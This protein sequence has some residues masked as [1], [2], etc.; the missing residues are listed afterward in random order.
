MKILFQ[1]AEALGFSLLFLKR[2]FWEAMRKITALRAGGGHRG[3]VRVYLDDKFALSLEPEV[4]LTAR[5]AVGHEL[6]GEQI[7]ELATRDDF[8]R[9]LKAA[10]HYLDYRPRSEAELRA[11]L[12]RRGFQ[13]G[14]VVAVVARFKEH[15]LVDDA[16][17]A[18]FWQDNRQAFRPQSQSLTRLE[19]KRKGVAEE[20]INGVI[21]TAD[22]DENAYRAAQRKARSL[23]LGEYRVFRQRLGDYLRRRGFSYGVINNTVEQLWR[24]MKA[25]SAD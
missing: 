8:E 9:C 11:R 3:R 5:L 13:E 25:D 7:N 16:A 19:L 1:K 6:S 20:V 17:F 15:G 12:S 2:G 23:P 4:V 21:A 10:A 24:E 18:H 14:S 22:D